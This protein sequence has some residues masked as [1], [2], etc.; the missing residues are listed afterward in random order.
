MNTYTVIF[1][2]CVNAP[3]GLTAGKNYP[4]VRLELTDLILTDNDATYI[5]VPSAGLE[6]LGMC[7]VK[8]TFDMYEKTFIH[9]VLK[10]AKD[11]FCDAMHIYY[12]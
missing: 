8:T 5:P 10:P 6:T 2:R 1:V 4:V 12:S 3:P 11:D 7:K 9:N